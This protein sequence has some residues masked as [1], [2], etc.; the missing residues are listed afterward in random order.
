MTTLKELLPWGQR[1]S[2]AEI[3][4]RALLAGETWTPT[5]LRALLEVLK[6][7]GEL[8]EVSPGEFQSTVHGHEQTLS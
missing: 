8:M 4:H 5:Q 3:Y 2:F 7:S 6:Q 1:L